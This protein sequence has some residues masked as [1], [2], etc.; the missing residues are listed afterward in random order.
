MTSEAPPHDLLATA[1]WT[2]P[3]P[4]ARV[5][6]AIREECTADLKPVKRMQA[7]TR[8]TI[9]V[10]LSV[11]IVS[12]IGWL[13]RDIDRP[14]GMLRAALVGAV[15]WGIVQLLVLV[16][17]FARAPGRRASRPVG[18]ALVALIPAA[19]LCYVVLDSTGVFSLERLMHT[20]GILRCTCW[21]FVLGAGVAATVLVLWRRSDPF[22]PGLSGAL[23]GLVGGL[24]GAVTV[25]MACENFDAWHLC[26][27]H[28]LG[29]VLLGGAG[30]LVGRRWLAP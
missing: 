8:T 20:E 21:S 13:R 17:S 25:G 12:T 19:F 27:G 24:T 28:T 15:G 1:E 9:A 10:A 16:S 11:A 29:L 22:D 14:E 2:H 7:G 30:W 26:I 5:A 18:L 3:E 4:S 6:A 23:S